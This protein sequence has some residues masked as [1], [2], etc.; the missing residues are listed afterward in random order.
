MKKKK[1]EE[2]LNTNNQNFSGIPEKESQVPDFSFDQENQQHENNGDI[3]IFI[4]DNNVYEPEEFFN[5]DFNQYNG[6]DFINESDAE[7][8]E[9][10]DND[11][12]HIKPEN[13]NFIMKLSWIFLIVVILISVIAVVFFIFYIVIPSTYDDPLY[14]NYLKNQINK[15]GRLIFIKSQYYDYDNG[16]MPVSTSE[17]IEAEFVE[18]FNQQIDTE[19][20]GAD[21]D[22]DIDYT[23]EVLG[24]GDFSDCTLGSSIPVKEMEITPLSGSKY[25]EGP[26]MKFFFVVLPGLAWN[27]FAF[28][29]TVPSEDQ[30]GFD[31][32]DLAF[33][34]ISARWNSNHIGINADGA[35]SDDDLVEPF[36][37]GFSQN[38]IG[39]DYD[40]VMNRTIIIGSTNTWDWSQPNWNGGQ[41]ILRTETVVGSGEEI[42]LSDDNSSKAKD[43]VYNYVNMYDDDHWPWS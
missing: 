12:G 37:R 27:N 24:G 32:R 30:V 8:Y 10:K 21:A 11:K 7:M 22:I 39:W 33:D 31:A 40:D 34:T 13:V 38:L 2:F 28:D 9:N 14:S 36:L 3:D 29:K 17:E 19:L 42:W 1:K 25:L 23:I 4:N 26:P 18:W 15:N 43:S 41:D 35:K 5:D 6:G 20:P 16:S